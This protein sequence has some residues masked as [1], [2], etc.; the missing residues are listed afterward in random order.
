VRIKAGSGA[1]VTALTLKDITDLFE[2]RSVVEPF[3][4]RLAALHRTVEDIATLTADF[5]QEKEA[6]SRDDIKIGS[7]ANANFHQHLLEASHNDLLIR[8]VS[9]LN[10]Q[11]QRLFRRTI[12]GN[13]EELCLVHGRIL[14]AIVQ[15]QADLAQRT[16]TE[17]VEQTRERSLAVA[18]PDD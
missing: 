18:D 2:V 7:L 1:S 16:T 5:D 9:P 11:I 8:L 14:S 17:H 12:R 15:Q 13:E 4:A 3:S 10:I 6:A